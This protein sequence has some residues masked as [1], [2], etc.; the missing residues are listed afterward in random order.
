MNQVIKTIM[1]R[2][3]TRKYKTEQLDQES[4]KAIIEA[5]LYAPS[6]HNEQS[7]HFTVIQDPQLID[8]INIDTK[9]EMLKSEEEWVQKMAQ[10]EGYHIFHNAP[11]V[12][13]VS[14]R[15]VSMMA[16][17][18]CG[19]ATQNILIAAESLDIGSCWVGFV[20]FLFNSDKRESYIK[21]LEISDDF[22]P[23]YAVVLGYKDIY[24]KTGP[25]RKEGR[26]HYIK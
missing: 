11:T 23:Y 15:K 6:A 25:S 20:T 16:R 26:V 5:G 24:V 21:R 1:N 3:S 9:I 10:K 18:D 8:D 12:I 7:W 4:L 14:G 2:R 13:I 22:T 19:A 17:E